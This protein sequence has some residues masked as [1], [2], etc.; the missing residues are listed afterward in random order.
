MCTAESIPILLSQGCCQLAQKH[1]AQASFT[2]A[3]LQVSNC[4]SVWGHV[5]LCG[6]I[7]TLHLRAG[8]WEVAHSKGRVRKWH[9]TCQKQNVLTYLPAWAEPQCHQMGGSSGSE[10]N[11]GRTKEEAVPTRLLSPSQCWSP[12]T[13]ATHPASPWERHPGPCAREHPRGCSALQRCLGLSEKGGTD[14]AKTPLIHLSL[15]KP[16]WEVS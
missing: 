10:S 8:Y 13:S 7:L 5:S 3:T 12:G 1:I 4:S 14:Q 16:N 9:L 15:M 11:K 2:Q 6:F